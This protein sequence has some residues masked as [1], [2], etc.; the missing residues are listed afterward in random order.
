MVDVAVAVGTD[1][2][3]CLMVAERRRRR[4]KEEVF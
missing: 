2:S 3:R 4:V 1:V